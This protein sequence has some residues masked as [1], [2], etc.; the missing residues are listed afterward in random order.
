[1]ND[2]Y[3]QEI[4]LK[5]LLFFILHKW[6]MVL[7]I[8]IIMAILVGGFK[9]GKGL[10]E[11]RDEEYVAEVQEQ[12]EN[13][14]DDYEQTMSGLE[15]DIENLTANIEYEEAYQE[16]SVLL[17]IDPYNK[18]VASA[19][20]FIQIDKPQQENSVMVLSVDPADSV[21]KA[22]TSA[23]SNGK[24]LVPLSKEKKIDMNY[25]K[26]LV[27]VGSDYNGNMLTVTVTYKDKKG[28]EE[29]LNLILESL[30]S[31]RTDVDS[32]LGAHSVIIMNKNIGTI[33]D[34]GLAN[35]QKD[36]AN[37]LTNLHKSLEDAQ[38]SLEDLEE[39][40]K[41]D[42]LSK[43]GIITSGI[44]Y[45]IL[46]G[47]L[48]VFMSGFIICVVFLMS[49]KVYSADE[50]KNRFGLKVLG[51]FNQEKIKRAFASIDNWLDCLEGKEEVQE[52]AVYE[53]IVTNIQNFVGKDSRLLLTGTVEDSVLNNLK[54]KLQEHLSDEILIDIGS[55]L[56]KDTTT[57]KMLP[58][59][60]GV[61]IA[62]ARGVSK[63]SQITKEIEMI[64]DVKKSVIGCIIL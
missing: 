48:G 37:N 3:E 29:I 2:T 6:R 22:Y 13:D 10:L 55:N 21:V 7:G 20:I 44:K 25:L 18:W 57:L 41:P 49:N 38:K 39:P 54:S 32:E 24:F 45:G 15:R 51:V 63:Y 52:E 8:A 28:A 34:T 40:E 50:L 46:G 11:H 59:Y 33:T 16:N 12:Y 58:E 61:I 42:S 5:D 14:I 26:E 31:M 56:N 47:V 17:Q 43:R 19:D 53:R 36:R 62:E 27:Q 35:A 1:M 9:F 64:Y 23:V 30:N 4:D 60:D